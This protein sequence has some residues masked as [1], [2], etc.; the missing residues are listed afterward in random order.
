[1]NRGVSNFLGGVRLRSRGSLR[2]TESTTNR[3]RAS[4]SQTTKH[5][6]F[7]ASTTDAT[8]QRNARVNLTGSDVLVK[9]TGYACATFLGGF[10]QSSAA[11]TTFTNTQKTLFSTRQNCAKCSGSSSL[12]GGGSACSGDGAAFGFFRRS[13]ASEFE[14]QYFFVDFLPGGC[15][16][17][18]CACADCTGRCAS[19]CAFL[20]SLFAS[21][22][23][24]RLDRSLTS[25]GTDTARTECGKNVR[26]QLNEFERRNRRVDCKLLQRLNGFATDAAF[27][28]RL[29]DRL[30]DQVLLVRDFRRLLLAGVLPHALD[31]SGQGSVFVV[32]RN[33][34]GKTGDDPKSV[35]NP[36]NTSRQ[37]VGALGSSFLL[38]T[39]FASKLRDDQTTS[40][41]GVHPRRKLDVIA[42]RK[43]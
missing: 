26:N 9:L 21:F 6:T 34:T 14:A 41:L 16:F 37:D 12:F 38:D 36:S 43:L 8:R 5:G 24:K 7:S 20:E 17:L 32:T 11:N 28:A 27:L 29:G 30:I 2:R 10:A 42:V 40:S 19:R 23:G 35:C 18:K 13:L 4:T 15:T 3:T 22:L 39:V 25:K 1:M 33:G 31:H